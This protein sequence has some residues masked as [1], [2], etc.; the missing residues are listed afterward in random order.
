MNIRGWPRD[1]DQPLALTSCGGGA[2]VDPRASGPRFHDLNLAGAHVPDLVDFA[3]A[4]SDNAA[5]EVIRD[6]NLLGL[7][8]MLL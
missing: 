8:L 4:F 2:A 7:K 3:S 6:K 5:N 1:D